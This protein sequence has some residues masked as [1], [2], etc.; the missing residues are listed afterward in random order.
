LCHV[1][2]VSFCRVASDDNDL[3]EFDYE[4]YL[5]EEVDL[6]VIVDN[7]SIPMVRATAYFL[8]TL[9]LNTNVL[10]NINTQVRSLFHYFDVYN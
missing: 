10:S 3:K 2:F 6:R 7:P 1:S 8:F 5:M 9:N 4:R